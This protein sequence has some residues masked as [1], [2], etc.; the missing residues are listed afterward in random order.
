METLVIDQARNTASSKADLIVM[1]AQE[2]SSQNNRILNI[3]NTVARM[4]VDLDSEMYLTPAQ[5]LALQ[6]T[7]KRKVGELADDKKELRGK[8]FAAAWR[9]VKDVFRVGHYSTIP[10][11]R[12]NEAIRFAEEWF[13]LTPIE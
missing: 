10:R 4:R 3:E 5:C 12:F 13:P 11:N 2:L 7:V 6:K 1:M 8:Y 9:S